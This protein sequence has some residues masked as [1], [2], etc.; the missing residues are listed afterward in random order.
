[1]L[2]GGN[3]QADFYARLVADTGCGV[4]FDL[5]NAVVAELNTGYPA[6]RWLPVVRAMPHFHIAGYRRTEGEPALVI[7]S[8]D[9]PIAE[10]TLAFLRTFERERG[11]LEGLT[12]VVERDAN[13]DFDP[14][15]ADIRAVEAVHA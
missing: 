5:S 10:D 3:D 4:L 15:A 13:I 2:G 8:H 11:G 7:D 12:L 9:S 1:M 6:L 14:W